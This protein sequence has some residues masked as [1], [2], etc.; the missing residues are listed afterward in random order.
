M[1]RGHEY[2]KYI[3]AVFMHYM[4]IELHCYKKKI[5]QYLIGEN[6]AGIEIKNDRKFRGRMPPELW[7]ETAEKKEPRRGNYAPSGIYRHDN[8]WL[9]VIGD[10]ATI[11]IFGIKT[12]RRLH[13]WNNNNKRWKFVQIPTSCAILLPLPDAYRIAEKTI[14]ID[15]LTQRRLRDSY[16]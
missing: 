9:F 16:V 14:E 10:Y 13:R 8:S 3:E 11:F 1:S 12:L 2:Q 7:I 6:K 5:E 15:E 4:D